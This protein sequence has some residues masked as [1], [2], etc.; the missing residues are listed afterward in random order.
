MDPALIKKITSLVPLSFAVLL[1]SFAVL[2]VVFADSVVDSPWHALD[3]VVD[4]PRHSVDSVVDSLWHAVRY[5]WHFVSNPDETFP[6]S[7]N[8]AGDP[9]QLSARHSRAPNKRIHR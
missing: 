5:E 9:V 8:V 6:M 2:A 4:S 1:L 3:S 7:E